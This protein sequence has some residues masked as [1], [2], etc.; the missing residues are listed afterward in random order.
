MI[1]FLCIKDYYDNW[2][3]GIIVFEKGKIYQISYRSRH[4]AS[5]TYVQKEN[6]LF[7][8][9]FNDKELEEYFINL[10]DW[11]EQQMKSILDE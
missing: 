8:V 11:R 5:G 10:A 6:S 3:T 4:M 7:D 2:K 1:N 9:R